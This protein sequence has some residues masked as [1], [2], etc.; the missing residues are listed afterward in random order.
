MIID[1]KK[2]AAEIY[3]DI[4]KEISNM[5]EKVYLKAILVGNNEDSIRYINQKRK[6]ADYVWIDFELFHYEENLAEQELLN[7]IED[8]NNDN[9]TTWFI[10]QLPLP[11]HIDTNKV[12]NAIKPEKDVDWFTKQNFWKLAIGDSSFLASCTPTWIMT[13]LEKYDIDVTG[14]N[15]V[16][17][18]RSNIVGK[19][20]SL[21]MLNNSA[22]ITTCHSR[23]K[24]ISYYTKNADIIC[25][26]VGIPEFLKADMIN[27]NTIVIDVW[28]TVRDWKIYWDAEFEA[29]NNNWNMITPVPG[30]V[31]AMTVAMLMQNTLKAYKIQEQW[32]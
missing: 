28:F 29:I 12:I 25:V 24:D 26:A 20:L 8:L 6:W 5:S 30:G 23:T 31:G 9:K 3:E 27:N 15:V 19:P 11:K 22:T 14:Q 17:I 4:K 1:W 13:L 16:V 32:K 10:V 21:M 2:I 7:K 18:G